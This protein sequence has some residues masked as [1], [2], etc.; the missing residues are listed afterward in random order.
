[1][2]RIA[3]HIHVGFPV[4][5]TVEGVA[6]TQGGNGQHLLSTLCVHVLPPELCVIQFN[7]CEIV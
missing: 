7:L 3:L 4:V 5:I 1:M 2:P 6:E